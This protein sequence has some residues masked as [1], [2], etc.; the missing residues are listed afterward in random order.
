MFLFK[1]VVFAVVTAGLFWLSRACLSKVRSH[2]FWRFLA[3]ESSL[4]LILLNLD[5]WFDEPFSIRQLISWSLLLISII[6]GVYGTQSLRLLGKHD[7]QREDPLL[8]GIEKTR[9]LVTVG[10]YRYVRHPMYSSF[11]FAAWGAFLKHLSWLSLGLAALTTVLAAMTARREEAENIR[12][13]G[14]A[15]QDYM[16]R[17]RMFI[18][19]LF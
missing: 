9:E 3:W 17:T 18:P 16:Q 10:A 13:F 15:Y 4:V 14:A 6:I 7:V 11:L 8:I 2:G 12:Y 1:I 19:F 5:Y